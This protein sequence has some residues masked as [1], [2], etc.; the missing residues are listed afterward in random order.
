MSHSVEPGDPVEF[1]CTSSKTF[2]SCLVEKEVNQKISQCNFTFNQPFQY[3]PDE[4]SRGKQLQRVGWDCKLDT[5]EPYRIRVLEKN[6]QM[7]CHL[8]INS[9]KLSGMQIFSVFI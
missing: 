2:H 9:A 8:K 4:I 6:N 1:H 5:H 7:V 3:S